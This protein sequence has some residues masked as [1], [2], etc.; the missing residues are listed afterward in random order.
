VKIKIGNKIYDSDK[1]PIMVTLTSEEK[2]YISC[3]GHTQKKFCS[4]PDGFDENYI[5]EFM[6]DV[7]G[8]F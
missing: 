3:M 1:E 6:Q 5:K 7:K 4:Y 8:G 2:I